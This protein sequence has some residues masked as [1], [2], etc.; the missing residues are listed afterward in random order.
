MNSGKSLNF[1]A[2]QFSHLV[3]FLCGLNKLLKVKYLKKDPVQCNTYVLPA[4][5]TVILISPSPQF[6]ER[7]GNNN[8]NDMS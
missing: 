1:P 8:N 2:P 7:A 4:V 5:F 6:R 3:E